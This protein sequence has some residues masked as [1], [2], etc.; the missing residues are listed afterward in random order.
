MTLMEKIKRLIDTSRPISWVNTAYP[1]AAGYLMTGGTIDLRWIIGTIFF[2]IPYNLLMYG[3]NDVFDYESDINNP[4]KGGVEGAIL[5]RQYHPM[6]LRSSILLA[7]PFVVS[8]FALGSWQSALVLSIVLFFVVAY[9]AK[10]LR[11]KEVPFLDSMTSSIHFVGPLV[12]AYSLLSVVSPAAW[13]VAAGFFAWGMASQAFG[14][15]QDVIPDRA[16]GIRSIATILG[17]RTTIWFSSLMYIAAI[18]VVACV[19]GWAIVV[20][21]AGVAYLWNSAQF[22]TITDDTSSDAR[23]GWR[24]FMWLNYIVGAIVTICCML[25]TLA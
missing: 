12:Y 14:A 25:Q 17:A 22:L 6:I 2:L 23:R 13:L 1:F 10:G 5:A 9:S 8:L 21:A 11:F 4:R 20:A 3:I 16:A 18:A 7:L 19:G 24:R 15:V